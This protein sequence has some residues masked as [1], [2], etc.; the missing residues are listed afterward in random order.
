MNLNK[1]TAMQTLREPWACHCAALPQSDPRCQGH[2]RCEQKEDWAANDQ[3]TKGD[4]KMDDSHLESVETESGDDPMFRWVPNRSLLVA[5]LFPSAFPMLFEA[6]SGFL[7]LFATFSCFK[8]QTQTK[9]N[10]SNKKKKKK[11]KKK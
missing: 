10:N 6:F 11:E 1:K 7:M 5:V 3:Q 9:N 4:L 8:R 2:R